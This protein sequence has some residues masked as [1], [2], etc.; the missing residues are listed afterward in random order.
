MKLFE[1]KYKA[2]YLGISSLRVGLEED[3]QFDDDARDEH[4][5]RLGE[6]ARIMTDAGQIFIT[7]VT[8]LDDYDVTA[9]KM[10]NEPHE[11]LVVNI[12]RSLFDAF[13]PDL[14]LDTDADDMYVLEQ[15]HDLL[16]KKKIFSIEYY[17]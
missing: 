14:M 12:G 17:L 6:L 15:I 1:L 16:E 8:G 13:E 5:R 9:L 4:I 3:L 11:I 2:Y 7:A 10:L